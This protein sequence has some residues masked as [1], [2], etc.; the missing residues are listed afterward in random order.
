MLVYVFV[1]LSANTHSA[2]CGLYIEVRKEFQVLALPSALFVMGSFCF[3]SYRVYQASW[4]L[5]SGEIVSKK[6]GFLFAFFEHDMCF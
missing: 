5:S 6:G 1:C 2:C 3:H 4:P